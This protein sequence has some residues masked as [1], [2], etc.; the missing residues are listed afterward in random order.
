MKRKKTWKKYL[1]ILFAAGM[2]LTAAC[3]PEREDNF[4]LGNP[5]DVIDP[6]FSYDPEKEK[7]EEIMPI[8]DG[9]ISNNPGDGINVIRTAEYP[10]M[11]PYPNYNDYGN[12]W[13]KYDEA[14]RT[15]RTSRN[16]LQPENEDYKKGLMEFCAA[17]ITE[18]IGAE[19]G[20]NKVYSPINVYMALS[21]LAELTDGES[22]AQIL[23]LL[24]VETIEDLRKKVTDIWESTYVDDG[25]VTTLL[26]NSLWLNRDISYV[27]ETMEALQEIYYASSYQGEMGSTEYNKL[28][29]S[30]LNEQT[31][32]LLQEQAEGVELSADTVMAIA[33]TL[34]FKASWAEEFSKAATEEK[35]F[36]GVDGEYQCEFMKQSDVQRVYCGENFTALAKPFNNS[37]CMYLV[38]PEEGIAAEEIFKNADFMELI[39]NRYDFKE[40]M[41]L[42]VN[43]ELPKFD[44]VSD[45]SLIDGLKNLGVTDVFDYSA[46]DF[47]PMTTDA[48]QIFVSQALHAARVKVDEEGCEA[49]AYTVITMKNTSLFMG[50]E[51]TLVFDR[52]FVF[53]ITGDNGLPLFT[54]VVNQPK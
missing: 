37:G 19:N 48:E 33:S 42:N 25:S 43:L 8:I 23:S 51:I 52:P 53:V 11:E 16:S 34:Y 35:P 5:E 46:S 9:D 45:L 21:M 4:E 44:V 13:D 7:S 41:S 1:G 26:G 27:E 12:N 18:F 6:G 54:G 49:A 15:W 24:Q 28:L 14:V 17:T 2:L 29:Q 30:W 38:L 50:D 3:G 40:Q 32:G 31:G 47:T 20:E 22:R 39:F 10:K 36:Y